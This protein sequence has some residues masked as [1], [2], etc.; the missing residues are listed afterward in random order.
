MDLRWPRVYRR[1][2]VSLVLLFFSQILESGVLFHAVNI[3][4]LPWWRQRTRFWT[5]PIYHTLQSYD[6]MYF[7][8]LWEYDDTNT[9]ICWMILIHYILFHFPEIP[10]DGLGWHGTGLQSS[11]L[12]MWLYW[13]SLEHFHRSRSKIW[14]DVILLDSNTCTVINVIFVM[15]IQDGKWISVKENIWDVYWEVIMISLV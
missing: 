5:G 9:F 10:A 2:N 13:C 1:S 12:S 11:L 4:T 3:W 15:S 14:Y 7:Q 8:I 6:Y